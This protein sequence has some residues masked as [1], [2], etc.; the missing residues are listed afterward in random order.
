MRKLSDQTKSSGARIII[1]QCIAREIESKI[2]ES[3]KCNAKLIYVSL[4][5]KH[6]HNYKIR[7][8]VQPSLALGPCNNNGNSPP[9]YPDHHQNITAK[10]KCGTRFA[11]WVVRRACGTE[12]SATQEQRIRTISCYIQ[13]ISYKATDPVPGQLNTRYSE[14]K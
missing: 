7:S 5:Y 8:I 11:S 9:Y 10:N 4:K 1:K 2:C 3:R 13:D 14:Q 6:K 12:N